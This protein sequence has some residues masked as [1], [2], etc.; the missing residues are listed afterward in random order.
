MIRPIAGMKIAVNKEFGD[1]VRQRRRE[2]KLTQLELGERFNWSKSQVS[3]LENGAGSTSLPIL[4]LLAKALETTP[5][6]LLG[7]N[8]AQDYAIRLAEHMWTKHYRE[9]APAWQAFPDLLGVLTQ[10][11]NMLTGLMRR[12]TP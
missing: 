3:R 10:I 12:P 2:L 8:R 6:A 7:F 5:D 4:V 1:R 11:D 9:D